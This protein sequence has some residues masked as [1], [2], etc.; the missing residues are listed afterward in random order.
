[1]TQPLDLTQ[2]D[3]LESHLNTLKRSPETETQD[4]QKEIFFQ[5]SRSG[6]VPSIGTCAGEEL[7]SIEKERKKSDIRGR[8]RENTRKRKKLHLH[9]FF[10]LKNPFAMACLYILTTYRNFFPVIHQTV[11]FTISIC[12]FYLQS[13]SRSSVLDF[14][15]QQQPAAREKL[16]FGLINLFRFYPVKPI[17]LKGTKS[18][19]QNQ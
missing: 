11:Y 1:M 6:F 12:Q 5:S 13:R 15:L 18:R 3:T 4:S 2:L 19:L 9:R 10:R 14:R 7:L 16:C 17:L 8:E